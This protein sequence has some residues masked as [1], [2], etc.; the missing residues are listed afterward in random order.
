MGEW[1]KVEERLPENCNGVFIFGKNDFGKKRTAK[2]LYARKY[3]L[4]ANDEAI[5]SGFFEYNEDEDESYVPEGWYEDNSCSETN[6]AID[7]CVTH[8]MPLP[9]PPKE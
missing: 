5:D 8:W 7:F 4:E 3:E 1:I 9:E 2:A 6:Y